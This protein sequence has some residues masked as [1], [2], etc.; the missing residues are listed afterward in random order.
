MTV[1]CQ[2]MEC[3]EPDAVKLIKFT[4][5]SFDTAQGKI[6]AILE[7]RGN[8]VVFIHGNSSTKSVWSHQ[9]AAVRDQGRTVLAPDL[10]GHGESEA[11]NRPGITYS[12]PGYATVISSLCENLNWTAF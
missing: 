3:G 10:P 5:H 9:I 1:E 2:R 6:S 11:A 7:G 8:P 4:S 12:I